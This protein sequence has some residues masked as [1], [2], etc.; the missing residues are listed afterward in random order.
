MKLITGKRAVIIQGRWRR[1][2]NY[3]QP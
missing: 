3:S 2:V 1:G